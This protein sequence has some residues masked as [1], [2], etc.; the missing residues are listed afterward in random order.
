MKLSEHLTLE[1]VIKSDTAIR[2]NISNI[3]SE[4]HLDN[5][6]K[7][8]IFVFEKIRSKFNTP[9]YI[10]SGYRSKELNDAVGGATKSDHM[11]GMAIDI[12][13]DGRGTVTN[14]EIFNYVKDNLDFKQ[15]IAEFKNINGG[16]DWVHVSYDTSNLKKEI[17]I[18]VKE[19]NK[20]KY[21][22]YSDEL[23]KKIYE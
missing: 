13:M 4:K 8:A 11:N 12:D 18:A 17:L 10:I 1:E 9:I 16:I 21:L 5:L 23:F 3:P 14:K 15:L 6:K 19:N 2:L 7:L 22:K 20:T